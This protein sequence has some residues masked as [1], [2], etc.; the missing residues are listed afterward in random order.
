MF[1]G[2]GWND[3]HPPDVSFKGAPTG[4]VSMGRPDI[5]LLNT[6]GPSAVCEV[7][8]FQ[9]VKVVEL[10]LEPAHISNKQRRWLDWW[11]Y[12][13]NGLGYLAIGSV[14]APR[15][16]FV[17]PWEDYVE[18]EFFQ[19]NREAMEKEIDPITLDEDLGLPKK[20]PVSL[21]ETKFYECSWETG[22]GWHFHPSNP[23]LQVPLKLHE[24]EHWNTVSLRMEEK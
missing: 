12:G 5:Y 6:K 17:V 1:R 19:R 24:K 16:L 21:F 22:K 15:R 8:T 23:I 11:T 7:K 18:L 2:I 4:G 10:W 3:Y 14:K 9:D 20:M 13:R